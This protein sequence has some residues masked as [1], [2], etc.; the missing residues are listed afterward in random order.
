[1]RKIEFKIHISK[2]YKLQCSIIDYNNNN[3][4]TIIELL[5]DQ[6]EYNPCI[7]FTQNTLAIC[8]ETDDNAIHFIKEWIETPNDYKEYKIHY[9][10]KEYSVIYEMLF[11]LIIQEFVEKI[12]KQWIIDHVVVYIPS[13]DYQI[14]LRMKIALESI[15]LKYI[16]INPI[17]FEYEKYGEMMS[18]IIE[19]KKEQNQFIQFI[20]KAK[21]YVPEE[22]KKY[23]LIEKDE[24]LT[25]ETMNKKLRRFTMKERSK[26]K[27]Y[28]L[29]NY[30]LFIA[31]RYLNTLRDHINLTFVSKRL[32]GNMEKYHYNPIS[33]TFETIGLFPNVETFHLYKKKDQ[34][35][36][37]GRIIKYVDW[38]KR[39]SEEKNT[40]LKM[41]ENKLIEFK[42][43]VFTPD[44]VTL[45][46]QRYGQPGLKY[47]SKVIVIPDDIEEIETGCFSPF[48]YVD[49]IVL[50]TSM[51]K[52]GKRCF[53]GCRVRNLIIKGDLRNIP[54]NVFVHWHDLQDIQIGRSQQYQFENNTITVNT[55][56]GI[57]IIYLPDSVQRVYSHYYY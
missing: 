7:S 49:R 26:M 22:K 18:E 34:Y 27:L 48:I 24:L 41:N 10:N 53:D 46:L 39:G 37:G 38:N 43:V 9:Q 6:K 12:V 55:S 52:F 16:E 56:N 29:D 21:Q 20:E 25:E 36:E 2:E 31:S 5:K 35:L 54:S 17:P 50:G 4:E 13:Q 40:I 30:C 42:H 19:K 14:A 28:R 32:K 1:M 47:H 23:L 44:D 51:K 3:H 15:G 11:G 33:L 45:Q 8:K 57:H